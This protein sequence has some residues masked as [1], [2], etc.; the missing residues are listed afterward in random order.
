MCV[1]ARAS[2]LCV[3]VRVRQ[4]GAREPR[5]SLA[6]ASPPRNIARPLVN[7][8]LSGTRGGH[9]AK[10]TLDPLQLPSKEAAAP[11]H[12]PGSHNARRLAAPAGYDAS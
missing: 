1:R 11:H 10:V 3:R 9:H 12:T 6:I 8:M 4:W 5:P 2:I 7:W